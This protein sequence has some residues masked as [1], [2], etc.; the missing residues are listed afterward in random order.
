[1]GTKVAPTYVTLVMGYLENKLYNII[2]N[3]YGLNHKNKFVISWKRYLDDCFV[4]WDEGID[5][6]IS[7]HITIF[8]VGWE[9]NSN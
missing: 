8:K 6:I 9:Y 5:K 3:K 1:M 4:I 7:Y 2:E